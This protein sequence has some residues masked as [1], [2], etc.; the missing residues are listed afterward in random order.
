MM[1]CNT[2][3]SVGHL[4]NVDELAVVVAPGSFMGNENLHAEIL[5][6]S[7]TT[8][9][10]LWRHVVKPYS[11]PVG[12]ASGDVAHY[13]A[14]HTIC[15]PAHW[16]APLIDG[17]GMVLV[18]RADG[19]MYKVYGP[20]QGYKGARSSNMTVDSGTLSEAIHLG[21][22]F[23]HGAFAA[24]PGIGAISSCAARWQVIP[25]L[26]SDTLN[27]KGYQRRFSRGAKL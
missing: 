16:S 21:S 1:P 8:G 15:L 27:S 13:V 11:G 4:A 9:E 20:A 22:G 24:A 19:S 17:K 10:Q 25:W 18:G 2:Y 12:Q 6:L 3:P 23:L 14:S 5:A 7:A 26:R